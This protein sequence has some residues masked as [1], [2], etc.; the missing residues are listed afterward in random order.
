MSINLDNI[1]VSGI[2][3]IVSKNTLNYIESTLLDYKKNIIKDLSKN[4]INKSYEDLEKEFLVK[5]QPKQFKVVA[6]EEKTP[7]NSNKCMAR[8]WIKNIGPKQCSRNNNRINNDNDM[9]QKCDIDND[10]DNDNNND[11][12][13]KTFSR[14]GDMSDYCKQHQKGLNYGRIDRE[15]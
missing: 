7:I 6:T 9:C 12:N 14:L 15:L 2:D 3:Y 4:F 13:R 5:K 11:T 1:D 8:V 10:I